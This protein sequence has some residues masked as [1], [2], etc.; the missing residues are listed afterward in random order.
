MVFFFSKILMHFF[1][2]NEWRGLLVSSTECC[3]RAAWQQTVVIQHLAPG[4]VS[5]TVVCC[6]DALRL[7]SP[8]EGHAVWWFTVLPCSIRG[9][10]ELR[11][12]LKG[13]GSKQ[14]DD[15]DILTRIFSICT[16][17]FITGL[18]TDADHSCF[19]IYMFLFIPILLQKTITFKTF[20][21]KNT[22]FHKSLRLLYAYT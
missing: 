21:T 19:T 16:P 1:I 10:T 18:K 15:C 14:Y 9:I 5:G 7:G 20:S 11:F 6:H 2:L 22:V 13:S 3:Y 4:H 8:V 17:S 12:D